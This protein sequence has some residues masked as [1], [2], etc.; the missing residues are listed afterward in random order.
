MKL[1]EQVQISRVAKK[2]NKTQRMFENVLSA[3]E[4]HNG[5]VFLTWKYS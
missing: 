1:S 2:G 3:V 4:W 5:K